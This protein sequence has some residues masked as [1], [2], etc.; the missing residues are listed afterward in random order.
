MGRTG[1]VRVMDDDPRGK[2]GDRRLWERSRGSTFIGE[3]ED[4]K[5]PV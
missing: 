1:N 4:P 5:E 2:G 3:G